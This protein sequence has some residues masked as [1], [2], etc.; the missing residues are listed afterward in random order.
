MIFDFRILIFDWGN[1]AMRSRRREEADGGIPFV[2]ESASSRRRLR[3]LEPALIITIFLLT[4]FFSG[5]VFAEGTDDLLKHNW[6]EARSAHFNIYS[7]GAT[8]E[9]YKLAARLEQFHDA[10]GLL[11]GAQAVSSPPITVMAFPDQEAINPFL[12]IYNG[13]PANLS[14]FFKRSPDENLIVLALTG[15]NSGSMEIIFHE[16]THL[17][18]RRNDRIWPIWLE[19]G[20]AEVYSTF[21]VSGRNVRI[22]MPIQNHLYVLE[23][24]GWMPLK[25]LL[26]VKHD[27]PQYNEAEH[28]GIFYAESWL[29]THFLMNGDNPTL[30]ARFRNFTKLLLQGVPQEQAFTRAL[31]MP[32][33]SIEAELKRYLER[34]QFSPINYVVAADLSRPRQVATRLMGRAEICFRLGNELMRIRRFDEAEKQFQHVQQLAPKSPLSCEGLGLLAAIREQH[35]EAV[36]QLKEAFQRGPVSFLAHYVYAEER[37][38]LFD[39]G[40]G[41]FKRLPKDAAEEIRANLERSVALM[42][43]FAPA[44]ELLG[45]LELV[46]GENLA[47]AEE[48]LQ[49]AIQLE[50]E[51]PYPLFSLAQIQM[52]RKDSAAARVT[53]TALR[54][55]NVDAQ[56][57]AQAAEMLKELDGAGK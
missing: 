24:A 37:L 52:R 54:L 43:T 1:A 5:S 48:H 9:V 38:H 7:C 30:K 40:H 31:G 44:H 42:P 34:K 6:F 12:P 3:V 14:G 27:S 18:F 21:A 11:A 41:T 28:Q 46:Q 22:G 2:Q 56:L 51:N 57:R 32:L 16:Y 36:R 17:L 4:L 26:A 53:L 23:H 29:L 19:E 35:D 8:R 13:K 55:P 45:F 50:P 15:T 47:L 10:Y 39:G 20:M 49:R 25:E 33:P